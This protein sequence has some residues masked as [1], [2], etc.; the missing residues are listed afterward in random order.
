MASC[1]VDIRT[2]LTNWA[3]SFSLVKLNQPQKGCGSVLT[4][5]TCLTGH[6]PRMGR[7]PCLHGPNAE[8]CAW[9]QQPA[10]RGSRDCCRHGPH[11][12]H[13]G[14]V[15]RHHV[16]S[17]PLILLSMQRGLAP[18][19]HAVCALAALGEWQWALTL[20]LFLFLLLP[21]S[22]FSLSL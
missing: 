2:C 20:T 5:R 21:P 17:F 18:F 19:E 8:W 10:R 16:S 13:V 11:G 15:P 9:Q 4:S 14:H 7:L 22:L 12:S 3:M 6:V 1:S